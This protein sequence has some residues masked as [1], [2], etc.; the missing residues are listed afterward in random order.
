VPGRL[1]GTDPNRS[2]GLY[3]RGEIRLAHFVCADGNGLNSKGR[4]IFFSHC[5]TRNP[6]GTSS[7]NHR[8]STGQD[9]SYLAEFLLKKGYEVHGH[10]APVLRVSRRGT[11]S[12]ICRKGLRSGASER[13]ATPLRRPRRRAP[14]FGESSSRCVPTRSTISPHNRT[15]VSRSTQP[16]YTAD[17][18]GARHAF[19]L[20]EALRD[21]KQTS[22]GRASKLYQAGS[23]GDVR[24]R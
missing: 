17:V 16:E 14:V 4:G 13:S 21:H 24:Q 10:G 6:D 8:A 1:E 11:K 9:G 23:S 15:C 19:R 3:G 5:A 7:I 18:C 20:L 2:I 22:A 12:I